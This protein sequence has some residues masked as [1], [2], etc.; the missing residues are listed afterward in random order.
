MPNNRCIEIGQGLGTVAGMASEF[1]GF[2]LAT[3]MGAA[4]AGDLE[5][6]GVANQPNLNSGIFVYGM[7]SVLGKVAKVAVEY[8]FEHICGNDSD[9][10]LVPQVN[11]TNP[12]LNI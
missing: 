4:R 3:I 10:A 9:N 12:D 1:A 5:N 6:G 7:F 8:E 2:S 11:V